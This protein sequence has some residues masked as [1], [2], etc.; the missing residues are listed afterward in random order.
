MK[1]NSG[2]VIA[3]SDTA[4][5]NGFKDGNPSG[6]DYV[7]DANGNMI[8]DKNKDIVN[9]EY[10]HLNL[11]K[12]I[13]FATAFPVGNTIEYFYDA[14][15]VKQKKVV[16][17]EN[18][19]SSEDT[20][21]N[22]AFIYKRAFDSNPLEL[23]FIS[24]PEGYIEPNNQGGYDYIYQYKDHLGN[25][26]LS[27][28]DK[29]QNDPDLSIDLEILEENNYY[30]FGLKHKG[31]NN[32]TSANVNAVASKFKYNGIELEESLGL[33]LYEMELRLYDP[34]IARW[35]AI[36]PVTHHS[37]ST[38]SAFDNNP[39]F[40]ADPSGADAD[41]ETDILGRRKYDEMGLYIPPNERGEKDNFDVQAAARAEKNSGGGEKE[42]NSDCCNYKEYFETME[43]FFELIRGHLADKR[44]QLAS[45]SF[46]ETYALSVGIVSGSA[47]YFLSNKVS[48]VQT[49]GQIGNFFKVDSQN[50]IMHKRF[51][52]S[53][54]TAGKLFTNLTLGYSA[55]KTVFG[56]AS[57][58]S[59]AYDVAMVG[60]SFIPF[61]G[62]PL[63]IAGSIY[64]EE[65]MNS[66]NYDHYN[67][68]PAMRANNSKY[69]GRF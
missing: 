9:I 43:E 55:Y 60:I 53:F 7:Y 54:K 57:W 12:K 40:W 56:D 38:Y 58:S 23:K 67:Q 69:G 33:N 63:S 1:F 47:S 26:R 15:G 10:N 66:D 17:M 65:I 20:H 2:F 5:D 39:V 32:V 24:Q 3:I 11:P 35:N 14:T 41:G 42:S 61:A 21:Y 31:Y 46:L 27:Y 64:K 50:A 51:F 44:N 13:Q 29:N 37:F 19:L 6:N 52:T 25:I 18:Q 68:S 34:A 30:P 45:E 16:T 28:K 59:L 48:Y 8:E 36:D 62:I 4:G 22:G 49:S